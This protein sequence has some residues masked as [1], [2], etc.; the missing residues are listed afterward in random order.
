MNLTIT[1]AALLGRYVRRIGL[2]DHAR[3]AALLAPVLVGEHAA[4]GYNHFC[5][6]GR[7]ARAVCLRGTRCAVN[8][9]G[10]GQ[11]CASP[12]GE[13]RSR[14]GVLELNV[15]PRV[16]NG[17]R[18]RP[19]GR[20]IATAPARPPLAVAVALPSD[21]D[22]SVARAEST[23]GDDRHALEDVAVPVGRARPD[24]APVD[25]L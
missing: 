23:G 8:T 4:V 21:V 1:L 6:C 15:V 12:V 9:A 20:D 3:P 18:A 7:D 25:V 5:T 2:D 11:Q 17:H 14:P 22:E 16:A 24:G 10:Q 13:P 19:H